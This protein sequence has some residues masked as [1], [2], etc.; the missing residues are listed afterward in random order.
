MQISYE[1]DLFYNHHGIVTNVWPKKNYYEVINMSADYTTVLDRQP[2]IAELRQERREFDIKEKISFYDYGEYSIDKILRKI[3]NIEDG[4]IGSSIVPKRASLFYQNFKRLRETLAY[5][6]TSFNCEHFA[7]YCATGLAFC[8]QKELV[9]K[10]ENLRKT[11][12]LDK[13]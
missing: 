13:K 1:R 8:K 6:M 2:G 10:T 12:L 5:A 7:S 9:T 11:D 3:H 4:I